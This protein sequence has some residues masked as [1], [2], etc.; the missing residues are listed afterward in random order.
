MRRTGCEAL[1]ERIF[2]QSV[3]AVYKLKGHAVYE[4]KG[5]QI[6]TSRA[7]TSISASDR[8][9]KDTDMPFKSKA[10]QGYMFAKMPKTAKRWAKET[11]N[12]KAL[13]KK[14]PKKRSK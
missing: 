4:L 5:V 7:E 10:Q 13:P 6:R 9:R 2:P 8:A 11:P 3:Q 1:G 14:A 12:I